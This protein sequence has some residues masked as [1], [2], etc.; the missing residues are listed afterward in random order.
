MDFNQI[1]Y[2]VQG[3]ILALS[4][5]IHWVVLGHIVPLIL[6]I[7]LVVFLIYFDFIIYYNPNFLNNVMYHIGIYTFIGI[8]F[9]LYC[10][11]IFKSEKKIHD[12]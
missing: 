7:V 8:N 11:L 4:L 3:V 1:Y 12:E 9:L 5:I 2:I 6:L 10:Y